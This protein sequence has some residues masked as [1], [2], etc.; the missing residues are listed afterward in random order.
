LSSHLAR[1]ARIDR[2]AADLVSDSGHC[3]VNVQPAIDLAVGDWVT[4]DG[5]DLLAVEPRRTAIVRAA[6]SGESRAQ[7]LVA[8]VDL[9]LVAVPAF[10]P[11]RLGIVE[12]LV[13]LAWDSGAT[14]VVVITKADLAAEP[15]ALRRDVAMG[16]VGC[17][18]LLASATTGEGM[19]A[20]QCLD[21]P[22]RTLCLVGRSGAGKSTLAN[23]LMGSEQMLV[24]KVRRDGKGRHTTTHRELMPLP[25]GGVLIDTPGLRGV[26]MWIAEDGVAQ[27]FPEIEELAARCRFGDCR[28]DTEPGCAIT[29]AIATG[30]LP[31]RR[32][33]SWRKLE[34]E[35]AWMASRHDARLRK[36]RQREWR[37]ISREVRRSGAIRP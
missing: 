3:R 23:A 36:E 22:G 19:A 7:T 18:V 31:Q 16:A 25:G 12:R 6:S 11:P 4:A 9:V 8:N 24:S 2:G 28:H 30:E 15:D 10:P 32:L 13:A 20:V 35:A 26:G 29:E 33:D 27:T 34:R 14:P 21:Q 17:D 5:T 1:V 37:Q